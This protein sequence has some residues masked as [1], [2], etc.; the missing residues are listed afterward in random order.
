[1]LGALGCITPE[2]LA[3]NGVPFTEKQK[4]WFTAGSSIFEEGGLNYLGNPSLIHAQSIIWTT[5]FTVRPARAPP[6][7][8]FTALP[9][10]SGS[11][12]RFRSRADLTD[13]APV[14][15]N[16]LAWGESVS[17]LSGRQQALQ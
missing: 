1:M 16:S 12:L 7:S 3:N 9:A 4:I 15:L 5:A 13:P 14:R 2:L 10:P 8:P 11:F 17:R 6:R